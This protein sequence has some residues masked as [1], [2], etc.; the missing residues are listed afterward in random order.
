M[1]RPRPRRKES[2]FA[3][4]M[5]FVMAACVAIA[6]YMEMPRVAFESQRVK[7]QLLI[8]RGNQYKRAIQLFFRKNQRYPANMDELEKYQDKRYLR[9]KYADPFTG[10]DDWRLIHV[11]PGG[12]LTDSLVQKQ[13]NPLGPNGQNGQN[14]MTAQ[15]GQG[16]FG[17]QGG[18]GAQN[19]GFGGQNQGQNPGFGTQ[20]PGFSGSQNGQNAGGQIG[21]NG[22]PIP[23]DPPSAGLNMAIA[24]RP[25]DR[26]VGQGAPTDPN[27]LQNSQYPPDPSSNGAAPNVSTPNGQ[28]PGQPPTPGA[29]SMVT[30]SWPPTQPQ[31]QN[32]QP[33]QSGTT[34]QQQQQKYQPG[35]PLYVYQQ[36]N[37]QNGNPI[38]GSLPGG[39]PP[40]GQPGAPGQNPAQLGPNGQP[41]AAMA[42]IQSA[43]MQPRQPPAGFGS[44]GL[45][46]TTASGGIAGVATKYKGRSI[47]VV[48]KQKRYQ[49]WE[50]VYDIKKDKTILGGAAQQQGMQNG[51][52]PGQNGAGPG[53]GSFGSNGNSNN[54]NGSSF[55]GSSSSFGNNGSSF[56]NN[57]SSFGNSGSSF[58]QQGQ[59]Q[60][61]P[62]QPQSQQ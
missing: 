40:G 56:G 26:I 33:G 57:G 46:S 43:L 21:P 51:Q 29:P 13:Q 62:T 35:D 41:N 5:V 53:F 11:G 59:Q 23:E 18:F 45:G 14:G 37:G 58:G 12:I 38:P 27:Q 8:D 44:S 42:A 52:M 20:N 36:N 55:G 50:F 2:G 47:K 19:P 24:R 22:Q 61:Q 3:L 48:E 31:Q 4:L 34:G 49:L 7:E 17:S 39:L 30:P 16:G 10:K 6:L 9:R 15:N 32:G 28:V 60:Q 1:T 25:S 54:S